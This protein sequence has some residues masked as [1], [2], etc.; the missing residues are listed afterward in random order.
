MPRIGP[1]NAPFSGPWQ[2]SAGSEFLT[3]GSRGPHAITEANDLAMAIPCV[4]IL[5]QGA[6]EQGSNR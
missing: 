5:T 4:W 1:L 6:H 2:E 3:Q